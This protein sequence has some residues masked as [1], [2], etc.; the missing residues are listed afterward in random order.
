[1][2]RRRWSQDILPGM[3]PAQAGSGNPR[4]NPHPALKRW[5]ILCG[6]Y[7][8]SFTFSLRLPRVPAS[9]ESLIELHVILHFQEPRLRELQLRGEVVLLGYQHLKKAGHA[10]L[11]AHGRQARGLAIGVRLLLD[12]HAEFARVGVTDQAV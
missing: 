4:R 6:A 2:G 9:A 12:L 5:A 1:M 7:G 11:I 8:A 3:P 10:A